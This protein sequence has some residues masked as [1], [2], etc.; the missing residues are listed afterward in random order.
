MSPNQQT[1]RTAGPPVPPPRIPAPPPAA[2]ATAA[3]PAADPDAGE[4]PEIGRQDRPIAGI[5]HV[6]ALAG[7]PQANADFYRGVLGLRLVKKTVNYDDPGTYHLYYGDELRRPGTLP[8]F[9]PSPPA[10]RGPL[11]G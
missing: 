7:D 10:P 4:R 5:H 9:F 2:P 6:T 8:T 3:P 1:S 11:G